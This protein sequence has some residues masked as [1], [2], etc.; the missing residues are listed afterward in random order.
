MSVDGDRHAHYHAE[1]DTGNYKYAY[2]TMG[3]RVSSDQH[4]CVTVG[5]LDKAGL[6][7]ILNYFSSRMKIQEI[8]WDAG[9]LIESTGLSNLRS[10]FELG[11]PLVLSF[12][13]PLS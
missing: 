13:E 7:V 8:R 1:S 2:A 12:C 5:T 11:R 9:R 10:P 3:L 6:D 4:I